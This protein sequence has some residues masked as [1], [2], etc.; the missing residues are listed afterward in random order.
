MA[1]DGGGSGGG[2]PLGQANTFTGTAGGLEIY[3]D[4]A[5]AYSGIT[6]VNNNEI[7]LIEFT[8]GNYLFVGEWNGYYYEAVYGEDFRFIV[9]LNG[10]AVEAFTTEGSI[11]GHSRAILNIIIPAFS[12]VKITAQNVEDSTAREM[13]ASLTGRIYR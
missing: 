8:S 9:Y 7:N 5:A 13:L 1:L 6:D 10:A 3:G 12:Q 2:P 4:F 11:R